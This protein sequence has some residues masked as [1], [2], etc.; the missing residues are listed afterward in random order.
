MTMQGRNIYVVGSINIDFVIPV[1]RAPAPGE[2]VSGGDLVLVPG[3]KGANQACAA[4]KL[5]AGRQSGVEKVWMVGQVGNDAF[6]PLLTESLR[7]A[8]VDTSL[9]RS[10]DGAS[11]CASIYVTPQ[12][13]NSIVISPG[14]N[15]K[16]DPD[17]ALSRLDRLTKKDI[18]LLQLEIPIETVTAIAQFAAE[19][20]A[21]VI[22]DP[23][24]ARSLP[25]SLLSSVDYLTPNETEARALLI[26]GP[27]ENEV[28]A[29]LASA[30]LQL[31]TKSVILKLGRERLLSPHQAIRWRACAAISGHPC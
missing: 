7:Q 11:G 2:T 27:K 17:F 13:E 1:Q 18:V 30:L 10:V 19:R 20:Q 24:P 25:S 5:S 6:A 12:G 31:G 22:L 9:V 15:A 8:N 16:V 29:T 3:G 14:A 28:W 26:E 21:I 4:G 23:A